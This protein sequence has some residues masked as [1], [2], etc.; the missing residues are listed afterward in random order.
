MV[1]SFRDREVF[2]KLCIQWKMFA[3][4]YNGIFGGFLSAWN[5]NK[6]NFDDFLTP[7]RILL[8]GFVR[9]VNR[10]LK[11]ENLYG[12]YNNRQGF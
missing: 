3:V 12:P 10:S 9:D 2:S 11:L 6:Y 5:T 4:D 8:E 1:C 7:T